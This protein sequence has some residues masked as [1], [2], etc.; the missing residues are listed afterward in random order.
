MILY[1]YSIPLTAAYLQSLQ[2]FAGLKASNKYLAG[3]EGQHKYYSWPKGPAKDLEQPEAAYDFVVAKGHN[4]L[5]YP[6]INNTLYE[7]SRS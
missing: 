2:T 3:P 5:K 6:K 4:F 1:K 7:V